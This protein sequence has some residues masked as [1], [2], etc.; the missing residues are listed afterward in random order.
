MKK[1]KI[2]DMAYYGNDRVKVV[3][4]NDRKKLFRIK[5]FAIDYLQ[6][7]FV[8]DPIQECWGKE[9]DN[10]KNRERKEGWRFC[11]CED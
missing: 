3:A 1:I 6:E 11:E 5:H 8:W 7:D 4:V 10:L 2:G 9:H